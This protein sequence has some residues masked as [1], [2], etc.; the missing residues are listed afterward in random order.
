MWR[1]RSGHSDEALA[2]PATDVR[3]LISGADFDGKNCKFWL[4]GLIIYNSDASQDAVVDI[5]DQDEG[6]ATA[7]NQRLSIVAPF[8]TTTIV[9]F[10]APGIEFK[11]NITA[12]I[13]GG[14]VAAYEAGAWGYEEGGE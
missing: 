6:A 13:T 12:G 11:T 7:A 4:R 3:E 9:E 1:P 5:Y 14:T 10:S 2:A 8:G